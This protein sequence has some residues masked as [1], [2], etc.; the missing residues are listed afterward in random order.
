MSNIK[1]FGSDISLLKFFSGL[2][3]VS[4]LVWSEKSNAQEEISF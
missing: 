4:L 2:I 3:L 1:I